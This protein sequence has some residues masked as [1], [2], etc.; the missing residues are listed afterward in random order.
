MKHL[1][2]FL[3]ILLASGCATTAPEPRVE[4]TLD[5]SL[6]GGTLL[7]VSP[8][9]GRRLR[10]FL[11]KDF[12]RLRIA[13]ARVRQEFPAA[14]GENQQ[15]DVFRTSDGKESQLGSLTVAASHPPQLTYLILEGLGPSFPTPKAASTAALAGKTD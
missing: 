9:A 6:E 13:P 5:H 2:L 12:E 10:L 15:W 4:I 11:T 3:L 1:A 8:E 7:V 14:V